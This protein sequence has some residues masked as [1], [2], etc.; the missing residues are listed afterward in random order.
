MNVVPKREILVH[1]AH[2]DIPARKLLDCVFALTKDGRI[3][4]YHVEQMEVTHEA[5]TVRFTLTDA[6]PAEG[7]KRCQIIPPFVTQFDVL[8]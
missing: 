6:Q 1:P 4:H 8:P 7:R 3:E 2:G 5:E